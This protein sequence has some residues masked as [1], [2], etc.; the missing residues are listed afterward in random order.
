MD[1]Q[2]LSYDTFSLFSQL[3][4]S[5]PTALLY[6]V[7]FQMGTC[8]ICPTP[9]VLFRP[10][11]DWLDTTCLECTV[12]YWAELG[13]PGGVVLSLFTQAMCVIYVM[14][15][16]HF[17]TFVRVQ[18]VIWLKDKKVVRTVPLFSTFSFLSVFFS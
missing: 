12:L 4:W 17:M 3:L 2:R 18:D 10:A 13:W 6:V 16:F 8:F 15:R 11:L 5:G 14:V 9:T 7:S 1:H